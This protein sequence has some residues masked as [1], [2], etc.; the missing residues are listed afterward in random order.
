MF[1]VPGDESSRFLNSSWRCAAGCRPQM[2]K[3]PPCVLFRRY[4]LPSRGSWNAFSFGDVLCKLFCA[5]ST[6][7]CSFVGMV[8][9]AQI[10]FAHLK[11]NSC[12]PH[13][14]RN[15]RPGK[16]YRR[17]NNCYLTRFC[18]YFSQNLDGRLTIPA[19]CTVWAAILTYENLNAKL[20]NCT[21]A[22]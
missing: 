3:P 21:L 4:F 11:P 22:I 5:R 12:S 2:L 19:F 16:H 14:E 7:L 18:Q 6:S 20:C 9:V 13:R 17:I 15:W 8:V 10:W 1:T